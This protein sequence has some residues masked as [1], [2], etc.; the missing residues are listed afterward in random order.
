MPGSA[1]KQNIASLQIGNLN[2]HQ[3][4]DGLGAAAAG[5]E[6]KM[7]LAVGGTLFLPFG[8]AAAE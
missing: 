4:A 3:A 2:R 8:S 7:Q 6:G 5:V 1:E